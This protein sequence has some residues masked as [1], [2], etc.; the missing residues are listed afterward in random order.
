MAMIRV[1]DEGLHR[2]AK[3]RARDEGRS[4]RWVVEEAL[5]EFVSHG[6]SEPR[7]ERVMVKP[8]PPIAPSRPEPD[9]VAAVMAQVPNLKRA[10]EI[11]V[12]VCSRCGHTERMHRGGTGAEWKR[13]EFVGCVCK[14]PV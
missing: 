3:A 4:L 13:C 6:V 8:V 10:V 5:R 11:T 12:P 9:P 7:L 1:E 2:Q 14:V